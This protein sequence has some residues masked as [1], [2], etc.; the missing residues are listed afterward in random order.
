MIGKFEL[1][2]KIYPEGLMSQH[3]DRLSIGDTMDFKHIPFNVK[4]QYPYKK[5]AVGMLA[6][7]RRPV[8]RRPAGRPLWLA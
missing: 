4:V 8:P 3:I 1:L 2:I 7:L 6:R 5:K